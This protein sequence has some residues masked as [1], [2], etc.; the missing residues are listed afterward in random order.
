MFNNHII[1]SDASQITTEQALRVGITPAVYRGEPGK[2]PRINEKGNWEVFN[3]KTDEWEDTGVAAA[4]GS[5]GGTGLPEGGTAGQVLMRTE[6]GY[7]WMSLTDAPSDE[8]IPI[9][10]F[11]DVSGD[12]R[13]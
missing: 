10:N 2:A 5:G 1:I 7:E 11:G 13:S 6:N 8:G 4:G 3:N 9:V 12:I